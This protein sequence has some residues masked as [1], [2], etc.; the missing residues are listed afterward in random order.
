MPTRDD[1][2][3]KD[4]VFY[5]LHVKAFSDSNGDGV[6]DFRGLMQRLDYVEELGVDVIWLLPTYPSP[7]RDDGYDIANYLDIHPSYGVMKDFD[8][9]I[10]EAHRRGL[11]VITDLV[12]NH[13]SD[14]HPWFQRARR[15]P[16]GS[17]ERNF[18]VWSDTDERY[19]D[20]RIIFIDSEPSN[21]SWDPVAGQYF[22]HRFF[23]H[24]PDLNWDNPAVKEA[25]FE[26]MEFWLDR[27][28]DGFRCDAVPYLIEREG[29]NCENLPETH[30]ILKEFRARIDAKYPDAI[31]LAEANQWPDD[32]RPYFGD[33]DEFHMAFHFPLMPRIF[34]AVRQE[35]R[36]P[37]VDIIE[38][39]P[40]IPEN[41]QWCMFLRNHDELTLEM[42]TDEERDYM[43]KEYA[44]DPRMRLNLGIRRRLAPLMENDRRKIEL[45][46]SILF[47]MPGSPIIYYGDELGMGDN[48]WLG[49]RDGVRTPMQWSPDR[50]AGFS[51]A[52]AARL[53]LPVIVDSVYGFQSINVEA[54][55]R[56]PFSLLNWT[57]R[58]I[59]VRKRHRAFGRGTIE[60]L[61]PENPHVLA[62]LREYEG[63]VILCVHNLS[64]AAQPVQ[65]DLSRFAGCEPVEL[66]GETRFQPIDETPYALTL[67]PFG[68]FWFGIQKREALQSERP[69]H[70]EA[71]GEAV[72]AKLGEDDLEVL[73]DLVSRI[74]QGW[75]RQQRWFRG[76]A[77]SVVD[78]RLEE[79]AVISRDERGLS[80]LLT[81]VAV[82]YEDDREERYLLPLGLLHG[83]G[84]EGTERIAS[85][86]R[87]GSDAQLLDLGSDPTIGRQLVAAI[88][89][90]RRLDGLAG[91]FHAHLAG[92]APQ[93][94]GDAP[95]KPLGGEQSNTSLRIGDDL[96]LKLFRLVEEGV[97]PDLEIG[98]ALTGGAGEAVTAPLAGWIEYVAE[99]ND[100]TSAIA[101]LTGFIPNEGDGW[102]YTVQALERGL[103]E[104]MRTGGDPD[105]RVE[106]VLGDSLEA[107]EALGRTT[108]RMHAAL[109]DLEG[110]DLQPEPI[111]DEH[112][113]RWI[114]SF[115]RDS[116]EVFDELSE[117][118]ESIPGAFAESIRSDLANLVRNPPRA[119]DAESRL[120][121]LRREGVLAIRTHGDYHLGQVLRTPDRGDGWTAIDFE[122]EVTRPVAERRER[123]APLRD[124]AGMLR[125]LNYAAVVAA[126]RFGSSEEGPD[127][128]T[129]L[130]WASAWEAQARE[131][132]MSG[133]F[134]ACGDAPFLPAGE[135]DRRGVL[136]FFELEKAVYEMGYEM[137]NRPDWL[138]IPVQGVTRLVDAGD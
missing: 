74:P 31:L 123:Q 82:R 114:E 108:A 24:Q 95:V 55:E 75:I 91:T 67:S 113:E 47:T 105:H 65:L 57:K 106:Q 37:I 136:S 46:N 28:L 44:A 50:N 6:G 61:K 41:T 3:Y 45:L 85:L 39:T 70:P 83:S 9:F 81:L 125:S 66:L 135:E 68:F 27:G 52:E 98:R 64:S 34:M 79:A 111:T 130:G 94:M 109:A 71:E 51:R 126:E 5:E 96:L 100:T 107:V 93:V 19:P 38:R 4:A 11:K 134:S 25:M 118:L 101:A 137:N 97:N 30:D 58:L 110:G 33:G 127:R 26:V 80:R 49:D 120:G 69:S 90:G 77:R 32:V 7:L 116:T 99:E 21:W 103:G 8:A 124:V 87:E 84:R 138:W 12:M 36:Q 102:S 119:A 76:K 43:Y 121:S 18:Y 29:T 117:R 59:S 78:I 60:F 133:Y 63:D 17:P 20:V 22:W 62:Y 88:A 40:D 132:F 104:L 73:E 56:S 48:I 42:V 1:L 2:W 35:V 128:D 131:R 14:Q 15:A 16:K 54:Q 86:S 23:H 53:Y 112:L 13:T 129:L 89:G 10:E 72:P 92:D 115:D 122:G